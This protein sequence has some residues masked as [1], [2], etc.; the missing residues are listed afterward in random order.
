[1]T[2]W[3]DWCNKDLYPQFPSG[4][5]TDWMLSDT[6]P[7]LTKS[8]THLHTQMQP[9]NT[10]NHT[11]FCLDKTK[12]FYTTSRQNNLHSLHSRHCRIYEQ[13]GPRNKQQCT[14]NGIAPK[15]S[16]SYLR[17]KT[18]VEHTHSQ[19]LSTSTQ[20]TTNVKNT[21]SNRMG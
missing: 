17:P 9:R 19:P 15:G 12:Q 6:G 7:G 5:F 8:R 14:T 20:S 2:L 10:Y 1:M 11:Y 3:V 18:H 21:H 4:T 16:G 13:S